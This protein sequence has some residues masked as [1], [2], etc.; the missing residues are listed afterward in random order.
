M[1]L[2]MSK[3]LTGLQIGGGIVG[4]LGTIAVTKSLFDEAK[5]LMPYAIGGL[6]LLGTFVIVIKYA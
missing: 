2:N 4:G 1:P 3:I 5:E 6:G